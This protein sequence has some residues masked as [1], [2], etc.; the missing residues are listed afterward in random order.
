MVLLIGGH[1]YWHGHSLA[2]SGEDEFWL[3][4]FPMGFADSI[5]PM[6]EKAAFAAV[7]QISS[8]SARGRSVSALLFPIDNSVN[9][10]LALDVNGI[11]ALEH[12]SRTGPG[13]AFATKPRRKGVVLETSTS[14]RRACSTV[15]EPRILAP[16][17][18]RALSPGP[19]PLLIVPAGPVRFPWG[20]L[21][22]PFLVV[23]FGAMALLVISVLLL[24]LVGLAL[25]PVAF[26]A[27]LIGSTWQFAAVPFL[28]ARARTLTVDEGGV[29]CRIGRSHM[30]W[31]FSLLGP[32]ALDN[33]TLSFL[34][35]PSSM[36]LRTKT[37]APIFRIPLL[38]PTRDDLKLVSEIEARCFAEVPP[39]PAAASRI[40]RAGRSIEAWCTGLDALAK[41]GEDGGYRGVVVDFDALLEVAAERRYDAELRA[42]AVYTLL[43]GAPE[44]TRAVVRALL[45][46]ASPPIVLRMARLA[47]GGAALGIDAA[48]EAAAIH[49]D[50]VPPTRAR[51]SD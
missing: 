43:A 49:L 27:A 22:I 15:H 24:G 31:P 7:L 25:T 2:T 16:A 32:G 1:T 42:G 8:C 34:S 6:A 44:A 26:V 20:E 41:A 18:S 50:E 37:G 40:E 3:L 4:R 30:Y 17:M 13:V 19:G 51:L 48:L 29:R 28:D 10:I 36:T 33:A 23:I 47:P 39:T 45:G 9:G 11:L 35:M 46:A 14:T 38:H 5:Q 21:V 12:Y